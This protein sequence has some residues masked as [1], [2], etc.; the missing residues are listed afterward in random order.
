MKKYTA[1]LAAFLFL[2][3][4][5]CSDA[6][7]GQE[8]ETTAFKVYVDKITEAPTETIMITETEPE[9]ETT[10]QTEAETESPETTASSASGTETPETDAPSQE[11]EPSTEP[12]TVVTE[13][14]PEIVGT[15]EYLGGYGF[16]FM[17]NGEAELITNFSS[18]YQL[19]EEGM[20]YC[21]EP[22]TMEYTANSVTYTCGGENVL[23]LE[24]ETEIDP[25][26]LDGRYKIGAC[27]L[28]DSIAASS[29][30]RTFYM[31]INGALFWAAV[32]MQYR[33][34]GDSLTL[35]QNGSEICMTYS[36]DEEGLHMTDASGTEELMTRV[37]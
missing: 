1:L 6:P 17:K 35:V 28:Y 2:T 10:V 16:R 5:G 26:A 3:A 21:G 4:A 15:W 22:C 18:V 14:D 19:T 20:L 12:E 24:S 25:F 27:L 32:P 11:T 31:D 30:R 34:S 23:T 7:E 9:T 33:I 29:G 8:Q 37:E 36:I 13:E